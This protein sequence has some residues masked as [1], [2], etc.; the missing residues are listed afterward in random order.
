MNRKAQVSSQ[1]FV[2]ILAAVVAGL[3][4]IIGAKSIITIIKTM[5]QVNIDDFKSG[6]TDTVI[7]I[8]AQPGSVKK[9]DFNLH[10]SFEE[11]CFVDSRIE[12]KFSENVRSNVL[13]KEYPFIEDSILNDAEGNV[14]LLKDKKWE[15][16]FAIQKL[17][18]EKDFLCLENE[19]LLTVWFRGTGK[20]ALLYTVN[21]NN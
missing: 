6:L 12:G 13:L 3:I 9:Y 8:S 20:N 7:T 10:E 14:F 17:D 11:I 2:Y 18:V 16:K 5:N 21:E 19:A 15:D 1:V 4:L